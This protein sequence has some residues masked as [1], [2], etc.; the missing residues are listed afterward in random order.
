MPDD[1]RTGALE[2][3]TRVL[4]DIIAVYRMAIGN[5][6]DELARLQ[7][8]ETAAMFEPSGMVTRILRELANHELNWPEDMEGNS[9]TNGEFE[10]KP[11]PPHE[12]VSGTEMLAIWHFACERSREAARYLSESCT[13]GLF[14]EAT[15]RM[16]LVP[17]MAVY[18][19]SD[20][21]LNVLRQHYE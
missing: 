11:M 7:L 6:C 2:E 4:L 15:L 19:R 16:A 9:V 3:D 18:A 20:A 21:R 17:L 8:H 14:E 10:D 1:E 12:T 13:R 5:H